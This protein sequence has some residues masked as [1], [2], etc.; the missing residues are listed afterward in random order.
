MS[1]PGSFDVGVDD[2]E[3]DLS[4]ADENLAPP[5]IAI[6]QVIDVNK[7]RSKAGNAQ[8]IWELRVVEYRDGPSGVDC[9]A[10]DTIIYYTATTRAALWKVDEIVKALA[11]APD[12]EG[13]ARFKRDQVIGRLMLGAIKAGEFNGRKKA[14]IESLRSYPNDP[15][16]VAAIPDKYTKG[17]GELGADGGKALPF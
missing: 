17:I 9:D 13:R 16:K 11:I 15:G 6:L 1:T 4:A 12:E 14:E 7:G 2:F 5:G 8:W 3:V 10:L